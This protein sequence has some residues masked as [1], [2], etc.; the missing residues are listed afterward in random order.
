MNTN[1]KNNVKNVFTKIDSGEIE[2]FPFVQMGKYENYITR[3]PLFIKENGKLTCKAENYFGFYIIPNL[4]ISVLK[5]INFHSAGNLNL[6][7]HLYAP[8]ILSYYSSAFIN[9]KGFLGLHGIIFCKA[10]YQDHLGAHISNDKSTI[11]KYAK[12]SNRWVIENCGTNHFDRWFKLKDIFK[13]ANEAPKVFLDLFEYFFNASIQNRLIND[14]I[15][16]HFY[17]NK[18]PIKFE[19]KFE[20]L[21]E[22]IAEIRHQSTYN[23][24]GSTPEAFDSARNGEYYSRNA[25]AAQ[26]KLYSNLSEYFIEVNLKNIASIINECK[27]NTKSKS[28]ILQILVGEAFDEVELSIIQNKELKKNI[29]HLYKWLT[30]EKMMKLELYDTD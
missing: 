5:S 9:L 26:T 4:I 21:L 24:F 27:L 28:A 17:K 20:K 13:K 29:A 18:N 2:Y 19:D 10:T 7:N 6:K 23:S 16:S 25:L 8:S 14:P 1:L 12:N 3:E 15:F 22:L 11:L 30:N